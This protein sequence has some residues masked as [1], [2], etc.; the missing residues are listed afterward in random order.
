MRVVDLEM[1][2][3]TMLSVIVAL[4]LAELESEFP[5]LMDRLIARLSSEALR[6]QVVRIR[7]ERA[8]PAALA[9]CKAM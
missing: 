9:G 6:A 7:G 3:P 4:G 5:G 8:L 2:S 1:P